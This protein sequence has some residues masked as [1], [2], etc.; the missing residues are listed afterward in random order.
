MGFVAPPTIALERAAEMSYASPR[1]E[2][3]PNLLLVFYTAVLWKT[4]AATK[5]EGNWIVKQ[6]EQIV[7]VVAVFVLFEED[8][9]T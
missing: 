3:F 2:F 9:V 6:L 5:T 1:R 4:D 7:G 8:S